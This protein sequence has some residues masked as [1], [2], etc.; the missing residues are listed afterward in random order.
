MSNYWLRSNIKANTEDKR[1]S[2]DIQ[3]SFPLQLNL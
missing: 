2:F 1:V 3:Q